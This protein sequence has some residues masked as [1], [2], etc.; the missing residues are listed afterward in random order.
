MTIMPFKH[1]VF[2]YMS[3]ILT[4]HYELRHESLCHQSKPIQAIASQD[5]RTHT[6]PPNFRQSISSI[7]L[8][9]SSREAL[10][11]AY[12]LYPNTHIVSIHFTELGSHHLQSSKND[13]YSLLTS[14]VPQI[15]IFKSNQII[16]PFSYT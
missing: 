13:I 2:P 4:N 6:H 8:Y 16:I 5:P 7:I 14:K 10:K 11:R 1:P 9:I 15:G 12:G 3:Y